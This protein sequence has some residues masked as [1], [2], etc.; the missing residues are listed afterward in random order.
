MSKGK[1]VPRPL[2]RSEYA[3]QFATN[4]SRKG[5]TDLVATQRNA[6]VEAWEYL[7]KH[8]DRE[9][10]QNH[11]L[12]GSLATVTHQGQTHDRWQHELHNGARIWFY[13]DDRVVHLLDV[14]TH[15]PNQTK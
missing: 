10:T 8:P 9:T 14:H 12:R 3:I 7:T 2:R 11:R 15:H 5:W 13:I 6:V 4:Q 1:G